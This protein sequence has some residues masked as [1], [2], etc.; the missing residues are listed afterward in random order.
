MSTGPDS[1]P[2]GPLPVLLVEDALDQAHLV[3]FLLEDTGEY[4]VTLVQDGLRGS[5]LAEEGEWALVITDLNLP[6]AYG[7]EVIEASRKAH[8]DT[9]ILA[10]TG[11]SGPEFADQAREKGVDEVLMKPLD[12][13][14]LLE[15]V[16]TLVRGQAAPDVAAA[17]DSD[18]GSGD[19]KPGPSRSD[20]ALQVLAVGVRPGE[21]EVGCAGTLL[22]HLRRGDRVVA[23][24]LSKG[25]E[26]ARE[27]AQKAGRRM[28]ARSFFGTANSEDPELFERQVTGALSGAMEELRPDV[29]YAPSPRRRDPLGQTVVEAILDQA[30]EVPRIFCYDAG[31]AT[32]EFHPTLFVPV[33]SLLDEKLD[34]LRSYQASRV[35]PLDPDQARTSARFWARFLDGRPGEA[36][37]TLRGEAPWEGYLEDD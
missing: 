15:R 11:Y 1:P 20:L 4:K 35:A 16:R 32:P 19:L 22:R 6:G 36:F 21:L 33:G 18:V 8:P 14:E 17:E 30:A 25:S 34:L 12:R 2:H 24:V 37:E 13:D 3:R 9:P 26:E 31:D 28:G 10:T 29:V 27:L 7:M 5:E 23:L